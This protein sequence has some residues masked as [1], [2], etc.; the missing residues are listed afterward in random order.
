MQMPAK[1][2]LHIMTCIWK[3]S[4]QRR[5]PDGSE[6][7]RLQ[8]SRSGPPWNIAEHYPADWYR[9]L[10]FSHAS[11][12]MQVRAAMLG[13]NAESAIPNGT[14]AD[15]QLREHNATQTQ[16]ALP[17]T[18]VLAGM[19]DEA[20]PPDVLP[21]FSMEGKVGMCLVAKDQGADL[22][23]WLD[24]YR[25]LGIQM[26][27]IHD[28]GSNPPMLR[29]LQ[30]DI[31]HGD[32]QYRYFNTIPPSYTSTACYIYDVC[33][34]DYKDHQFLGLIDADEYVVLKG[35]RTSLPEYLQAFRDEGHLAVHWRLF[36]SSGHQI[37]Q[38]SVR[39][40]YT[41]CLRD[42]DENNGHVKL[43]VNPKYAV[44]CVNPH[45]ILSVPD[46]LTVDEQHRPVLGHRSDPAD[47]N[48]IEIY[49]YVTK[50]RAEYVQKMARG[51]VD[52]PEG[53]TYKT[54][55]FFDGVNA[56][57]IHDCYALAD[58]VHARHRLRQTGRF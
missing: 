30:D 50:S 48:D 10:D 1:R 54:L 49:H 4:H 21:R 5:N 13:K 20:C 26:F 43:F 58:Q 46:K 16:A 45:T 2:W 51:N 53:S 55:A 14:R 3:C 56:G 57:A 41:K 37:R 6:D 47:V 32:I 15:R 7:R 44:R 35:G 38:A 29:A 34:N 28:H 24:H 22:P 31:Q 8:S 27:H 17:M 19:S 36:G 40:S 11:Q 25:S 52:G 9:R 33:I 23:E 12:P 42:D 18:C 39:A